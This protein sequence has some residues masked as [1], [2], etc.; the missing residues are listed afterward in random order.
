[1][2]NHSSP[3]KLVFLAALFGLIPPLFAEPQLDLASASSE[4]IGMNFEDLSKI[5][6]VSVSGKEEKLME[7]AAAIFVITGEDIR[8]SGVTTV[9]EALRLAPGLDVARAGSN[10]WAISSRGF[11]NTLANKLLVMVDGRS[12]YTPL[13]SGVYWD[14]L[15][16]IAINDIDRIEVIRGPG[17]A[18]WGANA[19]NG[20]INIIRKNSSETQ[21]TRLSA[22]AGSEEKT[23][24]SARYGGA[25]GESGFYRAWGRYRQRDDSRAQNGDDAGDE[26]YTAS[27]GFRADIDP[28]DENSYLFSTDVYSGREGASTFFTSLTPPF[29]DPVHL[30]TTFNGGNV[31]G[32]WTHKLSDQANYKF[33]LYYDRTRREIPELWAETRDTYNID[34]QNEFSLGRIQHLNWGLG[35]RA[36]ADQ[37]HDSFTIDFDPDSHTM[38]N[39]T[40]YLQDEIRFRPSVITTVGTKVEQNDYTGTEIEPNIRTAWLLNQQNTL[41]GSI[42]RAVRTPARLDR[43]LIYRVFESTAPSI[44]SA[45]G[46]DGFNSEELVAYEL[47]Y[48]SQ[49]TRKLYFTVATFFNSYDQLRTVETGD[50]L[51]QTD[52]LP[53]TEQPFYVENKM[54]G[55]SYGVEIVQQLQAT[56]WCRLQAQY[57]FL[58]LH[59]HMKEDGNDYQSVANQ[60]NADPENQVSLGAS[61]NLPHHFEFDARARYIDNLPSLHVGS[62]SEGDARIGWRG[63][64]NLNLELVG[65]NLFAPYHREYSGG[66]SIQRGFYGKASWEF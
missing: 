27:G 63:I 59:L 5:D 47:G 4:I 20:V 55:E 28:N 65:Q 42:S 12:V 26:W 8:R 60:E 35:Y 49:P 15:D 3:F 39:Y 33:L 11:N 23:F 16:S 36:S 54:W 6:V 32:K 50:R 51:N 56:E 62:Y 40:G 13:F 52:P 29:I 2:N 17:A 14:T 31:L 38:Q 19:V 41:W 34:F 10:T 57:S 64:R 43:D 9:A 66:N 24:G 1:M 45:R 58:E 18:Y 7:T 21:G 44:L 37:I 30:H 53:H 46:T 22:G 48:R 61:F 25:F